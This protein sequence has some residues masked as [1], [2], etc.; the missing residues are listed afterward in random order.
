MKGLIFELCGIGKALGVCVLDRRSGGRISEDDSG[1]GFG[2]EWLSGYQ[3][4]HRWWVSRAATQ[5]RRG[6]LKTHSQVTL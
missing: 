3:G 6:V 5:W 2:C 4:S 1:R